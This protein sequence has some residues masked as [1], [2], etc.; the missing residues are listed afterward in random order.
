MASEHLYHP[1]SVASADTDWGR[2]VIG[3]SVIDSIDCDE[4]VVREGS[5]EAPVPLE[6][7]ITGKG[8]QHTVMRASSTS[9]TESSQPLGSCTKSTTTKEKDL[10]RGEYSFHFGMTLIDQ[11]RSGQGNDRTIQFLIIGGVIILVS[12]AIGTWKPIH[13]TFKKGLCDCV[14]LA[15]TPGFG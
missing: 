14:P 6:K 12:A 13:W 1:N 9:R 5:R 2:C 7:D 10:E 8:T 3:G 11:G 4:A 15:E